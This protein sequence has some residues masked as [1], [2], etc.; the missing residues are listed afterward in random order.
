MVRGFYVYICTFGN[1][2]FSLAKFYSMNEEIAAKK[3]RLQIEKWE[4][5]N[6][7]TAYREY[8]FEVLADGEEVELGI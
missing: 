1:S 8:L 5:E 4:K 3:G 7:D 2:C 6:N